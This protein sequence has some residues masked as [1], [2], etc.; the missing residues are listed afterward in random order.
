MKNSI[1]KKIVSVLAVTAITTASSVVALAENDYASQSTT[2]DSAINWSLANDSNSGTGKITGGV[3]KAERHI[4]RTSN[5]NKANYVGIENAEPVPDGSICFKA[6]SDGTKWEAVTANTSNPASTYSFA[7]KTFRTGVV[8]ANF[9]IMFEGGAYQN[10]AIEF[11]GSTGVSWSRLGII[12]SK[13]SMRFVW[14]NGT[15]DSTS[16]FT[17]S[18]VD[19]QWYTCKLKYD[20]DAQVLESTLTSKDDPTWTK[21]IKKSI[22]ADKWPAQGKGAVSGVSFVTYRD[23]DSAEKTPE[24]NPTSVW[25]VDNLSI[26]AFSKSNY[27]TRVL[28]AWFQM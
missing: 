9:D 13:G 11:A 18:I 24:N 6:S 15:H 1:F 28:M 5:A 16:S 4:F 20:I 22:P 21:T 7:G 2:C 12:I 17:S 19:D 27:D 23:M 8:E 14:P 3:F 26:D 25:Y 10:A